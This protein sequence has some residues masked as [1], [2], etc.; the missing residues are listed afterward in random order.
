PG[1]DVERLRKVAPHMAARRARLSLGLRVSVTLLSVLD[2]RQLRNIL[3]V[4]GE[5]LYFLRG[6]YRIDR[7]RRALHLHRFTEGAN[8]QFRGE[9]SSIASQ[10]RKHPD[11]G[12]KSSRLYLHSVSPGRQ[13]CERKPS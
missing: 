7:S 9:N 6:H 2:Q 8:L 10:E 5:A 4:H 11:A 1:I 12:S 3:A 13:C